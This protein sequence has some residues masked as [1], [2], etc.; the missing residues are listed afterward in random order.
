MITKQQIYEAFCLICPCR[1]P[2]WFKRRPCKKQNTSCGTQNMDAFLARKRYLKESSDICHWLYDE[3][4]DFQRYFK[5][6]E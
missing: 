6:K 2:T 3:E 5:I 4:A 1:Y